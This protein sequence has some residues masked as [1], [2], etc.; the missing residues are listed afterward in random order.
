MNIKCHKLDNIFVLIEK[1]KEKTK[2][3]V[4]TDILAKYQEKFLNEIRVIICNN[5]KFNQA[6]V[7]FETKE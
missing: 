3:F 6:L 4:Q 7:F 1:L 2:S 5:D